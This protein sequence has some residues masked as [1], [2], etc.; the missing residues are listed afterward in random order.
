MAIRNEHR[1]GISGL[2]KENVNEAFLEEILVDKMSGEM[3]IKTPNGDIVSFDY[4]NRLKTN[5]VNIKHTGDDLNIYG[6][7]KVVKMTHSNN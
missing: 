5:L 4:N 1:F 6:N 2:S 3:L 7:I